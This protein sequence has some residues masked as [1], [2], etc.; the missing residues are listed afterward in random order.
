MVFFIF[1]IFFVF[2]VIY[3]S[4]CVLDRLSAVTCTYPRGFLHNKIEWP[5]QHLSFGGPP[6]LRLK[7]GFTLGF[8]T[9]TET[10]ELPKPR[11]A[12]LLVK[13]NTFGTHGVCT[14]VW[15]P[16]MKKWHGQRNITIP[17]YFAGCH[18]RKCS[19]LGPVY[20]MDCKSEH[21]QW[22]FLMVQLYG[23]TSMV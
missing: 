22:P 9:K 18:S 16:G 11:R 12:I 20:T 6:H 3:F 14:M 10:K 17:S 5:S 2:L 15:A 1:N 19:S 23:P 4:S 21:G 13:S 7:G 8:K